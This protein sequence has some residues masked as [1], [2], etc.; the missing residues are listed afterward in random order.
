MFY[1]LRKKSIEGGGEGGGWL[2]PP[3]LVRPRVKRVNDSGAYLD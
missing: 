1:P 2:H 3:P